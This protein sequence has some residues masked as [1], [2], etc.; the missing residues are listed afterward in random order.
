[1]PGRSPEAAFRAATETAELDLRAK[2]AGVPM[3]VILGGARRR[4]IACN[5]LIRGSSPADVAREIERAGAAGFRC[6]KLKAVNGGGALDLERV[7]AARWAAGRDAEL[8]LD[9]N[10]SLGRERAAV[11]LSGLAA[12]APLTVEQPLA[13]SATLEDWT[14]LA[15]RAGVALAAD[16]SLADATL[17]AALAELG[18]GL[19][20]KL[21]TVGGPAAAVALAGTAAG[22]AWLASSYETSIGVSAALHVACAFADE[23]S[24]CGLATLDLLEADLASGPRVENGCLA[25][26][27]APGLGVELD[28]D[29]LER[30]RA[31]R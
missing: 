28:T 25:L 15:A 8:R 27:D 31:D 18:I 26:P 7:G 12:F 30:Y 23:P 6:F 4:R 29:A 19:A 21:A 24:A 3:A 20:I 5:A 17:A 1:V 10:G 2:A 14:W 22:R 13:A 16:E 9:F 11:A